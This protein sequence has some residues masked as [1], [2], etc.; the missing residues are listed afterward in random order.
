MPPDKR[1]RTR[2]PAGGRDAFGT[3]INSNRP[4][5]SARSPSKQA[6]EAALRRAGDNC[7]V[8]AR[9]LG[10]AEV[11][12]SGFVAGR[13]E[14]VGACCMSRLDGGLIHG[15]GLFYA[16][17][18]AEPLHK[19]DDRDWFAKN[20][21]RSHRLR[22]AHTNEAVVAG[23]RA[24]WVVVRQIKPGTRFRIGFDPRTELTDS[25]EL[26]H[27]FFD[28]LLEAQQAGRDEVPITEIT[29]RAAAMTPRG[30]A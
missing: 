22:R 19:R 3:A 25:E 16:P 1:V 27:A 28:I 4:V 17:D 14:I 11:T 26:A 30:A 23:V 6:I 12:Y 29:R 21:R 10:H 8:C 18:M 5:D 9:P 20:P 2:D 24:T 13:L 15:V 7:S